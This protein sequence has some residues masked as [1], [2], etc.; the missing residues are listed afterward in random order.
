MYPSPEIGA[1]FIDRDQETYFLETEAE[2]NIL[3]VAS[4]KS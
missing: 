4:N 1:N 2:L 3:N